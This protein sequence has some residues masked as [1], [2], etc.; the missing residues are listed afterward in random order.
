MSESSQ[1]VGN[2]R[3]PLLGREREIEERDTRELAERFAQALAPHVVVQQQPLLP[4]ADP[5][6]GWR[7]SDGGLTQ[8]ATAGAEQSSAIAPSTGDAEDD[9]QRI[10]LNVETRDLGKVSLI[11]DKRQDGVRVVIGVPDTS[12][13]E[14]LLPEREA[15]ARQLQVTGLAVQSIQFVRQSEVGTVLAPSPS[16]GRPRFFGNQRQPTAPAEDK[17]RRRG[18]RKLNLIG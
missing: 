5:P 6:G 18:S 13:V 7:A 8:P 3:D 17:S 12:A 1:G 11:L 9:S 10:V 2:R 15:L 16:V 4:L 14:R